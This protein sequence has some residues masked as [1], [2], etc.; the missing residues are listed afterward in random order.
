MYIEFMT[1]YWYLFAM[2]FVVVF[3]LGMDPA[4]R[5][6]GGSKTLTPSQLPQLQYREKAVVVDLNEK[7][8]FKQGH[9]SQAIN[10]PYSMFADSM[11]KLRKYQHK[12]VILVC[13]NGNNS[14]KAVSVLKKNDFSSI[15][16][17]SGGLVSWKKENLPIEKN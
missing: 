8:Q 5:G 1:E 17:L 3:L 6:P 10:V 12:P 13:E 14:R 7:D 11:G 9:I 2:L 15:Y 16:V 4:Q